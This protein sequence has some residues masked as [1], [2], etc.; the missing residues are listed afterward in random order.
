MQREASPHY[1]R[2][3]VCLW[4][5]R[6]HRPGGCQTGPLS[7]VLQPAGTS[8][9]RTKT[10]PAM[11]RSASS[12]PRR[13]CARVDAPARHCL[14]AGVRAEAVRTHPCGRLA[15]AAVARAG[16]PTRVCGVGWTHGAPRRGAA[17]GDRDGG[18]GGFGAPSPPPRPR[19]TPV[20]GH[21]ADARGRAQRHAGGGRGGGGRG[22]G[23]RGGGGRGGGGRGGGGR[24][25]PARRSRRQRPGPR[26]DPA[27]P[28]NREF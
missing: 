22:G 11:P 28:P 2:R 21:G 26:R 7:L 20:H 4:R 27:P 25:P 10:P 8:D 17:G 15:L 24:P 13:R 14:H 3:C 23:G 9:R 16:G 12:A 5:H 1:A 6:R 18:R 19:D